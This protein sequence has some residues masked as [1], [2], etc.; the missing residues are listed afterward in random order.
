MD[1]VLIQ[2]FRLE[3]SKDF[4]VG[5]PLPFWQKVR[6]ATLGLLVKSSKQYTTCNIE[7]YVGLLQR[8][9]AKELVQAI[10]A[11]IWSGIIRHTWVEFDLSGTTGMVETYMYFK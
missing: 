10:N 3:F 5:R 11:T 9:S 8:F 1:S 4:S 7:I 6:K 2:M